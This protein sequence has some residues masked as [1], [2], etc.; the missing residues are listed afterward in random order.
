MYTT[1]DKMVWTKLRSTHSRLST[2]V[3]SFYL[4][5]PMVALFSPP[6][7]TACYRQ[8]L[9]VFRGICSLITALILLPQ[10]H[11][12][13]TVIGKWCKVHDYIWVMFVCHQRTTR[14]Q[15]P[16]YYRHVSATRKLYLPVDRR[17]GAATR[18][19][20]ERL[21]VA[22]KIMLLM[23]LLVMF[24]LLVVRGPG[25]EQDTWNMC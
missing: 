11:Y 20:A 1:I 9:E 24:L 10:L 23:N 18:Y 8:G 6:P 25:G 22:R 17:G 5:I 13:T 7:T 19:R 3:S 15:T 14:V 12:A 21:G 4:Q 2:S 16:T